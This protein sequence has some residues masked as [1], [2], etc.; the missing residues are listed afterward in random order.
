ME[1][2]LKDGTVQKPGHEPEYYDRII[3]VTWTQFSTKV[4]TKG[5]A[6]GHCG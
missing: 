1:L 4:S 5:A 3:G 6:H 2:T